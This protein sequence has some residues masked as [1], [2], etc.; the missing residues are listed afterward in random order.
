MHPS[1][2]RNGLALQPPTRHQ[3][4]LAPVTKASIGGRLEEVFQVYL[5]R[6]RQPDS[7]PLVQPPYHAKLSERVPQK[8]GKFIRCMY[9]DTH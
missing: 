7:S 4:R 8:R 6:G 5:F 9:Q 2:L 3:D 1:I